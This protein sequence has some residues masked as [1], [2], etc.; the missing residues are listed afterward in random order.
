MHKCIFTIF[1]STLSTS[2]SAPLCITWTINPFLRYLCN[3]CDHLKALFNKFGST[4]YNFL[5]KRNYKHTHT[6]HTRVTVSWVCVPVCVW[7]ECVCV[8]WCCLSAIVKYWH[9]TTCSLIMLHIAVYQHNRLLDNI[10]P[11]TLPSPSLPFTPP[12]HATLY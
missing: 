8:L 4:T 6:L 2:I 5:I 12:S 11:C 7:A 1:I 9:C 3:P 10:F